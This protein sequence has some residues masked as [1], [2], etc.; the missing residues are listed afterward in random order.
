MSA[1]FSRAANRRLRQT[2]GFSRSVRTPRVIDLSARFSRA[3][4]I[5]ATAGFS[6]KQGIMHIVS[7]ILQGKRRDRYWSWILQSIEEQH[8]LVV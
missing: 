3:D 2:A 4:I 7:W 5:D 8:W 1:G 6:R